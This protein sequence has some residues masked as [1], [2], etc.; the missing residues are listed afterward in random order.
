MRSFWRLN[1]HQLVEKD[2][3][4]RWFTHYGFTQNE[5]DELAK[6]NFENFHIQIN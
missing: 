2:E 4:Q 5:L 3:V 1:E 6:C